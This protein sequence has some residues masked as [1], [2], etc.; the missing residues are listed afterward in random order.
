MNRPAP[1]GLLQSG[2]FVAWAEGLHRFPLAVSRFHKAGFVIAFAFFYYTS[3][4]TFVKTEHSYFRPVF[5]S[6]LR[7][8][9]GT[10]IME[11]ESRSVQGTNRLAV[12]SEPVKQR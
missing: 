6:G 4:R 1:R 8:Q 10:A 11:T 5:F 12:P 3:L 2:C 7:V 9:A